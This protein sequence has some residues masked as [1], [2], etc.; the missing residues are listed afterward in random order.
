MLELTFNPGLTLTG[1]RTTRPIFCIPDVTQMQIYICQMHCLLKLP[2]LGNLPSA[3]S[4][5]PVYASCYCTFGTVIYKSI[6]SEKNPSSL[7]LRDVSLSTSLAIF[8]VMSL[9]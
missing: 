2:D 3:S 8:K 9:I 5:L 4:I 7:F 6:N 1:F